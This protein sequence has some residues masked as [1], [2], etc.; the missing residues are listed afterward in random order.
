MAK[1]FHKIK[2]VDFFQ[3]EVFEHFLDFLTNVVAALKAKTIGKPEMSASFACL[4]F[5]AYFV[6]LGIEVIF[7]FFQ[8]IFIFFRDFV[9]SY[10]TYMNQ[11]NCQKSKPYHWPKIISWRLP[12]SYVSIYLSFIASKQK[13]FKKIL[14]FIN[15]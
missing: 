9:K 12:T 15:C 10:R 1:M 2:N 7:T 14:M 13:F 11:E 5:S 4:H 8:A 3:F 6:H